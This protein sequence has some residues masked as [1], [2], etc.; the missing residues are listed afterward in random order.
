[1]SRVTAE[2][3]QQ[4]DTAPVPVVVVGAHGFGRTHL[5]ALR[6]L[7]ARGRARLAGVC[8]T[9]PVDEAALAG[10][11]PVPQSPD[12]GALLAEARPAVTVVAT[13]IPTHAALS[14]RAFEAGSHVLLEKPPVASW[15]E[16]ERLAAGAERYGRACQ[17]G[18]QSVGSPAMRAVRRMVDE[19]AIGA[20]RG[21]G[22]AANWQ[23]TAAYYAR[24]RWA[25]HRRLDGADVVDGVLTNPVAHAVAGALWLDGS[26]GPDDIDT[27]ELELFRAN[28]IEADDTSAVRIRTRRGTVLTVA[29]TLC[30]PHQELPFL[31]LHGDEGSLTYWYTSHKVRL[32]R[33]GKAPIETEYAPSHPLENLVD[34]VATGAPLRCPLAAAAAYT[35]VLEAVRTAPDPVEITAPHARRLGTGPDARSEIDGIA[36]LVTSAAEKLALFSDLGVAWAR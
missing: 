2:A 17:V 35:R 22:G 9:A 1:M 8:D 29:A 5:E 26:T 11:G 12:L 3:A 21:I 24:A 34:H 10:F 28:P 36:D 33:P 31:L 23:R 27:L 16:Y 25:G 7:A 32:T 18:F 13:P 6:G 30:A 15:A 4:A 20:L 19:G 14:L